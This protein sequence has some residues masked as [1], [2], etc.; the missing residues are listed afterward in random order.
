MPTKLYNSKVVAEIGEIVFGLE[1]G[2]VSTLGAIT[3][4][5]VGSQNHFTVLL[6][7]CVI[8][9]VESISMAI[10]SFISAFSERDIVRRELSEEKQ[11]INKFL[12]AETKELA[13]MY[14]ADGWPQKLA[15]DMAKAA[16]KN[17]KLMLK[18]MAYRELAL[19]PD[20]IIMPGRNAIF[21]FFSYT[22]GGL[23]P[24]FAYFIFPV[25]SAIYFSVICTLVGLFILGIFTA[26]FSK[27]NWVKSGARILILGGV[28]LLVG[29]FI[30]T[31]ANIISI[32]Q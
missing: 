26:R 18:E 31:I 13:T 27:T 10:G 24:L 29:Y 30:G 32:K 23:I 20:K 3:G 5:A 17:K 7:G 2:M 15:S 12:P 1:D 22:A 16:S 4:I 21:M 11:E 28:A 6:S 8:I 19:S 25:K 9:A 14:R